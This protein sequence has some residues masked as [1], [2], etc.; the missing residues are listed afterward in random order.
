MHCNLADPIELAV[1][2]PNNNATNTFDT[3]VITTTSFTGTFEVDVTV[4]TENDTFRF[5]DQSLDGTQTVSQ[6]A[7]TPG[8]EC[9]IVR[10]SGN[11]AHVY[12]RL[13][14]VEDGGLSAPSGGLNQ[15]RFCWDPGPCQEPEENINAVNDAGGACDLWNFEPPLAAG[16]QATQAPGDPANVIN[17]CGCDVDSEG[18]P[19]PDGD[20]N[21]AR[22]CDLAVPEGQDGACESE[23]Q[24]TAIENESIFQSGFGSTCS[25]TIGRK[26][27][28]FSC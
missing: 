8:V 14:L 17:F 13:N 19:A 20:P 16:L 12:A 1:T 21:P 2:P 4:D 22:F 18:I 24:V 26:T 10:G 11:T 25:K 7:G 6:Q 27:Y 3:G 9:V 28:F 23:G 5:V 15:I